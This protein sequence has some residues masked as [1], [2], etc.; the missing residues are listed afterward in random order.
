M[1]TDGTK[2]A[3]RYMSQ[4][5]ASCERQFDER[6][7]RGRLDLY[8][9]VVGEVEAP[10]GLHREV[11]HADDGLVLLYEREFEG[12]LVVVELFFAQGNYARSVT[13]SSLILAA[14]PRSS[15]R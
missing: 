2:R 13:R 6:R 8:R 11:E 10:V 12:R 9:D 5:H 14:R 4:T 7:R 15:R 1:R 3:A